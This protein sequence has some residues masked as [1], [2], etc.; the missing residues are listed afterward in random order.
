[1]SPASEA[2]KHRDMLTV[3]QQQRDFALNN[4]VMLSAD[5]EE[6]KR[7][8]V[9]LRTENETLQRMTEE[10]STASDDLAS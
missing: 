3:M 2:Q 8:I 7:E 6:A 9:R 5:L 1:M 4:V 10:K